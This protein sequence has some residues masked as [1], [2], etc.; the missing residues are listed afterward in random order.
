MAVL[1][2]LLFTW[3]NLRVTQENLRITQETATKSQE[4][5]KG[6][7][8]TALPALLPRDWAGPEKARRFAA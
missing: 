2:S 8:L 5:A 7:L 1:F 3:G 6:K 4:D